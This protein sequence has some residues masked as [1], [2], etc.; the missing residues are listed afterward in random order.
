LKLLIHRKHDKVDKRRLWIGHTMYSAASQTTLG[1]G[2]AD[3]A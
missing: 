1:V 2:P 3:A